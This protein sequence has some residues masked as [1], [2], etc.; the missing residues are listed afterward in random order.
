[1]MEWP[2]SYPFSPLTHC[3][4]INFSNDNAMYVFGT[5]FYERLWVP[6][7]YSNILLSGE[8]KKLFNFERLTKEKY[9]CS[10]KGLLPQH[11]AL[12][13]SMNSMPLSA[14]HE[15]LFPFL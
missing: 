2:G 7:F 8:K 11:Q 14:S 6:A 1:M 15:C 3:Y 12:F 4:F 10:L 13:K 9:Y 5:R